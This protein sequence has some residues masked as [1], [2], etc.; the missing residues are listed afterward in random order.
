MS[1]A[2]FAANPSPKYLRFDEIKLSCLG[3]SGFQ[4]IREVCS[5][6]QKFA[7]LFAQKL[8]G[9]GAKLKFI[10]DIKQTHLTETD[11][12][13]HLM[14]VN[15]LENELLPNFSCCRAYEFL[16]AFYSNED[17]SA[18]FIS[19]LLKMKPIVC[20]SDVTLTIFIMDDT[21]PTELPVE[22]IIK[23]LGQSCEAVTGSANGSKKKEKFLQIK[24]RNIQNCVEMSDRLTEVLII[25]NRYNVNMYDIK[26]TGVRL[27]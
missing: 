26:C 14:L 9:K 27:I 12:S 13:D 24:M 15:Y 7:Q 21:H 5:S 4:S 20:C 19:S 18:N 11:F 16:V 17:A 6:L 22:A 10:G 8:N 3:G 23:W 25:F 2:D 1:Y